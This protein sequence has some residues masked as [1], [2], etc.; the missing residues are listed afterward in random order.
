MVKF[1]SNNLPYPLFAKEGKQKRKSA[2]MKIPAMP[3]AL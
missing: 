2:M 1:H 3:Y